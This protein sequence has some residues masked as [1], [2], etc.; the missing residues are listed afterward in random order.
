MAATSSEGKCLRLDADQ[1]GLRPAGSSDGTVAF[2]LTRASAVKNLCAILVHTDAA[3]GRGLQ[4]AEQ[5][6]PPPAQLSR[7]HKA[8]VGSKVRGQGGRETSAYDIAGG[9]LPG[10]IVQLVLRQALEGARE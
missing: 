1:V 3:C 6:L 7:Q 10:E 2:R 8:V 5:P 4:A 9:K